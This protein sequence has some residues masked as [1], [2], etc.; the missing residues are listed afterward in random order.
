MLSGLCPVCSR[1]SPDCGE[2]IGSAVPIDEDRTGM[3][4]SIFLGSVDS[5]GVEKDG[6]ART[7]GY[8]KGALPGPFPIVQSQMGEGVDVVELA[9]FVGS[10]NDVKG[11]ILQ[12]RV[13]HID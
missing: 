12:V 13:D 11:S 8:G 5:L 3:V 4:G 2:V 7:A 1:G 6:I 10:G 9:H